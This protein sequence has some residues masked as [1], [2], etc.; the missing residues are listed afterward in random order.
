MET[1]SHPGLFGELVTM[2]RAPCKHYRRYKAIYVPKCNCV[3]CWFKYFRT[4]LGKTRAVQRVLEVMGERIVTE[5]LGKKYLKFF[6]LYQK[7]ALT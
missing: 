7:E 4:N 6:K 1:V 2:T 5:Q 3:P